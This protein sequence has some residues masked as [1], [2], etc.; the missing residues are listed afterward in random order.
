M[1]EKKNGKQPSV[2]GEK[3]QSTEDAIRSRAYEIYC[4]RN[5]AAGD[6]VGDWLKAESELK[7]GRATAG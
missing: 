2:V 7:E 5:G 1:A 4:A 3:P 6:E